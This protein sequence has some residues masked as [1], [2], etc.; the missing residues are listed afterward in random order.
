MS[1]MLDLVKER[2]KLK[3]EYEYLIE[4]HDDM[5][6][7][8]DECKEQ[9][10]DLICKESDVNRRISEIEDKL[11][12]IDS[13][14]RNKK[15]KEFAKLEPE[16]I[17]K[18]INKETKCSI[19]ELRKLWK[20]ESFSEIV[21]LELYYYCYFPRDIKNLSKYFKNCEFGFFIPHNGDCDEDGMICLNIDIRNWGG[22]E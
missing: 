14:E 19:I 11:S 2:D 1:T 9:R 17:L 7:N 5:C 13:G 4:R 6:Y 18:Q 8:C 12:K 22:I 20:D 21:G 16:E 15:L 10:E 3:E